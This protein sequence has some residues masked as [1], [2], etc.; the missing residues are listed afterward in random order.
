MTDEFKLRVSK[1]GD[2]GKSDEEKGERRH[3]AAI[4]SPG[5]LDLG[6]DALRH[7]EQALHATPRGKT[8]LPERA[9]QPDKKK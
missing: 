8:A 7:L 9:I 6:D 1:A 5:H 4:H 2:L 3:A